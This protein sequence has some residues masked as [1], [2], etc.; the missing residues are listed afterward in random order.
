MPAWQTCLWFGLSALALL[1]VVAATARAEPVRL[2]A[3]TAPS[4]AARASLDSQRELDCLALNIYWEARSEPPVGQLAVASVVLNRVADPAF[5]DTI[6]D[7]VTEGA[8]R[9]RHRCQFSWH[10]D[11]ERD[12]PG[13]PAAWENALSVARLALDGAQDDPSRGALWYHSDRVR[14]AWSRNMAVIAR[15]GGHL[16]YREWAAAR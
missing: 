11:G 9:G 3:L 16:F 13:N 4:G 10:C 7:V 5:P 8:E 6:C 12:Q 1:L 2:A 15:I 14:P